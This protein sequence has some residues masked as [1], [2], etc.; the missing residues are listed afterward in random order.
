[1]VVGTKKTLKSSC[2]VENFAG[3]F[4]FSSLKKFEIK[5][6]NSFYLS[7]VGGET[8]THSLSPGDCGAFWMSADIPGEVMATD[9]GVTLLADSCF[10]VCMDV[11]GVE[12]E[13]GRGG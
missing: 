6:D 3:F 13:G 4:F 7:G 10:F 11:G 8:T 5:Q 12:G 2:K 9:D 1:M